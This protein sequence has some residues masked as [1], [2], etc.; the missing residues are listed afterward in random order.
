MDDRICAGA[1]LCG[2]HDARQLLV[3]HLNQVR[4]CHR[5][6]DR[7]CNDHRDWLANIAN[8]SEGQNMMIGEVRAAVQTGQVNVQRAAQD[9][10][11]R[12]RLE[13]L[14]DVLTRQH[15]DNAPGPHGG[16]S[17]DPSQSRMGV[18][19]SH[20]RGVQLALGSNVIAEFALSHEKS[21][22]FLARGRYRRSSGIECSVAERPC[23][24]PFAVRIVYLR[25]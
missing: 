12:N 18:R 23:G 21:G 22:I 2:Q 6:F 19:R 16:R 4:P 7:L 11:V 8:L 25:F 9:R 3:T 14:A 1:R 20:E 5:A 15:G 13:I 17:L 10:L 24:F